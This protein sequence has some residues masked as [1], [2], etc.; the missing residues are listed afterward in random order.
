MKREQRYIVLKLKD[1]AN[2]LTREETKTLTALC[3][4]VTEH[5]LLRG[6]RLLTCVVVEDDW[7]EYEPT[8]AALERR[9]DSITQGKRAV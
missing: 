4:K 3:N 6:A 8:W 1:L 9:M 2:V 7:P 5:R